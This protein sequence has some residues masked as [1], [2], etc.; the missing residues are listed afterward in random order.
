MKRMYQ[1][2]KLIEFGSKHLIHVENDQ[3]EKKVSD[4][5]LSDARRDEGRKL[6]V[7]LERYIEEGEGREK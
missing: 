6:T 2:I 1:K 3:K 7:L 4:C 5:V